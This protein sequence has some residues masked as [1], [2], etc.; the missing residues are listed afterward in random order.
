MKRTGIIFLLSIALAFT[1]CATVSDIKSS[2]S[3]KVTSMTSNVDPN[4][5]AKVPDDK[6]GGF[7]KAEFAVK[8]AEE[9]SKLANMRSELAAKQKKVADYQEDLAGIDVKEAGLDYDI[10]KLGA[11]DAAG[12]GKK[13]DNIKALTKLKLK[14]V[15]LDGDRIKAEGNLTAIKQQMN[16]LTEKI[17]A[18][19]EQIKGLTAEKAKPEKEADVP[20]EKDK[21]EKGKTAEEKPKEKAPAAPEVTPAPAPAG[22][23][24]PA[25]PAPEAPAAPAEKSK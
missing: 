3:T 17:K 2:V 22:T 20:A 19:E 11:I 1:G 16:A 8:V 9:K 21:A 18:Q 24:A 25:A 13:D 14:K 15:D 6:R 23:V 5:V 12:L 10:V 4:L 7:P